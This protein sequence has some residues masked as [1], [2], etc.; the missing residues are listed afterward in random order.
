MTKA[1]ERAIEKLK[2]MAER[3]FFYG[4]ADKYEF[5]QFEVNVLNHWKDIVSVTIETGLK[6]DEGTMAAVL[7]REYCHVF[8]GP[9]GGVTWYNRKGTMKYLCEERLLSVAARDQRI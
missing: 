6:G 7:C 2:K 4:G 3:E 8:V 9:R 1:Q 5:K